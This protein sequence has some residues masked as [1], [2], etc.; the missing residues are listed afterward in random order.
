[1]IADIIT[2]IT[3][4]RK[5]IIDSNPANI[6]TTNKKIG[7]DGSLM[8]ATQARDPI[9]VTARTGPAIEAT[10]GTIR[11]DLIDN[12]A[13]PMPTTIDHAPVPTDR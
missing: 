7:N 2:I 4:A 11:V 5:N 13:T 6:T 10:R 3:A 12:N 8:S 1:M 9:I